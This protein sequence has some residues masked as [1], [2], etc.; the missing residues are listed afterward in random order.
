MHAGLVGTAGR[1]RGNMGR[2]GSEPVR[3]ERRASSKPARRPV[4]RCP[5]KEVSDGDKAGRGGTP[6]LTSVLRDCPD[7]AADAS[8]AADLGPKPPAMISGAGHSADGSQGDIVGFPSCLLPRPRL[9]RLRIVMNSQLHYNRLRLG[10]R[11]Y[12][13]TM[14]SSG[15][16][17]RCEYG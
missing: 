2:E 8:T 7:R 14:R 17:N 13:F 1:E 12:V 11:I 15:K 10:C 6:R 16:G 3:N 4:S 5:P 9:P